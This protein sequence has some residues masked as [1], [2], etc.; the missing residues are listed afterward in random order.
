MFKLLL[1]AFKKKVALNPTDILHWALENISNVTAGFFFLFG[2]SS[3]EGFRFQNN[4]FEYEVVICS[5]DAL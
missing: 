4:I 5:L 2:F 3:D 1:S